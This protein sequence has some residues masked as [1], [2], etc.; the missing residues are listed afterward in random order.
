M[1]GLADVQHCVEDDWIFGGFHLVSVG[2]KTVEMNN[3]LDYK[4]ICERVP[5]LFFY[6]QSIQ[7]LL[8]EDLHNGSA[9]LHSHTV[10]LEHVQERQ[11]T[12]LGNSNI[13]RHYGTIKVTNH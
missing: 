7:L 4:H 9:H 13:G 12:L 5:C 11:E 10:L 1:H 8:D 6:Y 2:D 3:F